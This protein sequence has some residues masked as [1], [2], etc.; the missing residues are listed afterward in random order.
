MHKEQ[1]LEGRIIP[2]KIELNYNLQS[3]TSNITSL[4]SDTLNITIYNV[5]NSTYQST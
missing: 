5:I 2:L 4:Q 1:M 3:N